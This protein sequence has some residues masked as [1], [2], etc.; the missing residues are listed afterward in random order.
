MSGGKTLSILAFAAIV[1][2]VL[3]LAKTGGILATGPLGWTLQGAAVALMIWARVTFGGR[4]FHF[5][6]NPTAGGLVTWG[7]Y[8]FVRHPIYASIL[9]FIA[10]SLV[11]H[12][13]TAN[14]ALFLVALA[15]TA[16]RMRTEETLVTAQ[17]PEYREYARATSRLIPGV[18]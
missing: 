5:A 14:G 12:P 17:Y 7:P 9:L 11:D 4:S 8:G 2:A 15:G 16:V 6:A 13:T 1:L 18:W 3:G 10:V